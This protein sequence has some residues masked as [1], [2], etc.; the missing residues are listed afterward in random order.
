MSAKSKQKCRKTQC[1]LLP[2]ADDLLASEFRLKAS[3]KAVRLVY[4]NLVIGNASY[5][6]LELPDELRPHRWIWANTTH[7]P[8][9][10]SPKD[11]DV[12]SAGRLNSK[13]RSMDVKLKD[14]PSGSHSG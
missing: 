12:L 2:V 14:Q 13:V 5:D 4:I 6:P 11:Y 8:M 9:L 3:K 1:L 10:S 7:E